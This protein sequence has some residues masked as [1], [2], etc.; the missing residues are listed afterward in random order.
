MK[1]DKLFDNRIRTN[2][3]LALKKAVEAARTKEAIDKKK[4]TFSKIGHQ[5]GSKNSNYGKIWIHNLEL[6]I[7]KCIP[8]EQPVPDGWLLGRKIYA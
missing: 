8:K 4:E 3:K 2:A 6:K 7:S 1:K 5:K